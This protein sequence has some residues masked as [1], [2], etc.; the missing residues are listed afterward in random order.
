MMVL[1]REIDRENLQVWRLTDD[2]K[3]LATAF[4]NC[5]AQKSG[6]ALVVWDPSKREPMRGK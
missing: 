1:V 6:R 2:Q 5:K 3:D 4:N